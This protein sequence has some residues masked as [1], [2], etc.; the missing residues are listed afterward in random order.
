MLHDQSVYLKFYH[1][2]SVTFNKWAQGYG[3]IRRFRDGTS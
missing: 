3:Y 1:S 2:N